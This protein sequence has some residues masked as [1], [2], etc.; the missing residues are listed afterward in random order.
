MELEFNNTII[1]WN[2][3]DTPYLGFTAWCNE[4]GDGYTYCNLILIQWN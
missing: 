3:G 2:G 1:H 4:M